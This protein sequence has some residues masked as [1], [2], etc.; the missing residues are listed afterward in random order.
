MQAS[1][2]NDLAASPVSQTF[3]VAKA[4][5]T[6]MFPTVSFGW[7]AFIRSQTAVTRQSATDMQSGICGTKRRFLW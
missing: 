3:T 1:D 5:Q 4:N 6:I 7:A 2:T